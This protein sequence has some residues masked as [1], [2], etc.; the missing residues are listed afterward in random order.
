MAECGTVDRVVLLFGMLSATVL[1]QED[2]PACQKGESN[3]IV[4]DPI[5][6]IISLTEMRHLVQMA[7]VERCLSIHDLATMVCTSPEVI[8]AFE[9][10]DDVPNEEVQRSIKRVLCID[11]NGKIVSKK[12]KNL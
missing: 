7:R 6:S 1:A 3:A 10:G 4:T 9:R 8:A 11:S 2:R 5:Q 12:Q